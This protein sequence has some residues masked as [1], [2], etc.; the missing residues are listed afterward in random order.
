MFVFL[1]NKHSRTD[2]VDSNASHQQVDD[3]AQE[4]QEESAGLMGESEDSSE[5]RQI[6]EIFMGKRK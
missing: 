5:A 1:N 3:L 4:E 2:D 6:R